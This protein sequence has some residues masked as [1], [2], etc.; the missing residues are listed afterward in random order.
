MKFPFLIFWTVLGVVVGVVVYPAQAGGT[1][2]DLED[3]I[4]R[5]I[6]HIIGGAVAG[7]AIGLVHDRIENQK[8]PR[9][10]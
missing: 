6:G 9:D 5:L 2:R 7:L 1:A 3:G 4:W 10:E 8:T